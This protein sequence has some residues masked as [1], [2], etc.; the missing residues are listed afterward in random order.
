MP[1]KDNA[2]CS[3]IGHACC[4]AGVII[5]AQNFSGFMIQGHPPSVMPSSQ[6]DMIRQLKTMKGME[7]I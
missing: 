5:C 4:S 1:D 2:V 7:S 6:H 3:R